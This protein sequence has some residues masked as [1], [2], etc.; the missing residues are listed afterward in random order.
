[1]PGSGRT[2]RIIMAIVAFV[3]IAGLL[4]TTVAAPAVGS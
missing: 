1:M 3:V 4:A 2:G